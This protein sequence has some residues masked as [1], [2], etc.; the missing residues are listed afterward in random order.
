MEKEP[1]LAMTLHLPEG[2]AGSSGQLVETGSD[3]TSARGCA[4]GSGRSS[5]YH[6]RAGLG[7]GVFKGGSW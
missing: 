1:A 3:A 6:L 7:S 4:M 5:T 2:R